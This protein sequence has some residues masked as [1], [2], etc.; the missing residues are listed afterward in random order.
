MEAQNLERSKAGS[1]FTWV[2]LYR[3]L[4]YRLAEWE[5]RQ[6]ELIDLLESLR[7]AG[8]V[9]SSMND[10]DPPGTK[11]RLQEIDPFTFFGTFNRGTKDDNRK[12]ILEAMKNHFNAESDVPNDFNGIPVVNN[13][14]SWFIAYHF[15]RDPADVPRLWRIFRL[16]LTKDPLNSA[17]FWAAFDDA[18][19]VRRVNVNLTMGLFW[20]RPDT[21]VNLDRINRS[22]LNIELPSSGLTSDFYRNTIAKFAK[23]DQSFLEISY[24]AWR[25]ANLPRPEPLPPP[26]PPVSPPAE[27]GP[28]A[29][30]W[31]ISMGEG[32][33]LWNQCRKEGVAAI[34]WDYL[35]DLRSYA[36]K[37]AIG[38]AMQEHEGND[39]WWPTND[40]LACFQFCREMKKG[41]GIFAKQGRSTLLGCGVV[42]SDYKYEPT[43]PEY[44]N[45]RE[46]EW[47]YEEPQ[48]IPEGAWVRT[49]TLTEITDHKEFLAFAL[50]FLEKP[51]QPPTPP[52][53]AAPYTIDL[54]LKDVF[55]N[56]D[57]FRSFLGSLSR[58]KNAVIQGPPGVG[59][60]FVARRLAYLLVGHEAADQVEMVQFHQSYSYE[61]FVQGWRPTRNG[62]ELQNGVFFN[63][64]VK[65]R[66]DP[67][68]ESKYVFIIDEINRGNLSKIFG[69]LFVL[70]EGD[71]RGPK[72]A[73]PLTYAPR[74][75]F[76]VPENLFILGLMNTADR[77]LAMVDYALRRRFAFLDLRPAF[78]KPELRS[79]L[80]A[81]DVAPELINRILSRMKELN[82]RIRN[83]KA[84]LG[85]GFEIGHSFFCPQDA[86]E[87]LDL[88]WYQSIVD[89]EIA[90][91]LREYWFDDL[92]TAQT[93]IRRLLE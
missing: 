23:R 10:Q 42:T 88:K 68:P 73:V 81:K 4:A 46:V 37:D 20:I 66:N 64:C 28:S 16:A 27:P 74:E 51:V 89:T 33:R 65:A 70:I 47:V 91:L 60:T 31:A 19:K 36:D 83:E 86:D 59:K 9:V 15:H 6:T 30:Y 17:D 32:G 57:E 1:S 76:Y 44:R 45:V 67:Q 71:K 24:D 80:A 25:K 62:F 69:E 21:F 77:S 52:P 72:W 56:E 5:N 35:G 90:P 43:R 79:Y 7:K 11:F 12:A 63:F 29:C 61:D 41:D 54:A 85:E 92:D 40:A 3:E 84:R 75:P 13:Q 50:P 8:Y 87:S 2:P 78:D 48:E 14:S 39:S 58:K 53:V 55:I 22:Y 49:K 18:L 82:E 34:G 93:L 38:R 26:R